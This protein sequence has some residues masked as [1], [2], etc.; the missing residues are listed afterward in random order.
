M[1]HSHSP[2]QGPRDADQALHDVPERSLAAFTKAHF[3]VRSKCLAWS[4]HMCEVCMHACVRAC[5]PLK[6]LEVSLENERLQK[7]EVER[8]HRLLQAKVGL[9]AS[10]LQASPPQPAYAPAVRAIDHC[11]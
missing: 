3:W 1:G 5:E 6:K 4:M 7:L 10:V 8:Q 9:Q 2:E 11:A